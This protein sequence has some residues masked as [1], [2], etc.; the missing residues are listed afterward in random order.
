MKIVI[1]DPKTA[2]SY[3]TELPKEKEALLFGKHI[4]EELDG[5]IIGAAGFKLKITGGSD[6]DGFPMKS[7]IG[8]IG[9]KKVVLSKGVGFRSEPPDV[10]KKKM[11][12]A[13][14]VS[15]SISQLNVVVLESG[16]T[17]LDQLFPKTAS[18]EGEKKKEEKPKGK[19]KKK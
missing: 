12:R 11:I 19:G 2:K 9:K 5:S 18:A 4:G 1:G 17:A 7:D 14:T 8:G 3:Q 6:K 10:R 13:G 16:P 15:D